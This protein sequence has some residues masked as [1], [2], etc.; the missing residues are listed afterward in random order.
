MNKPMRI[1]ANTTEYGNTEVMKA[2]HVDDY[3]AHLIER[4]ETAEARLAELQKQKPAGKFAFEP[5]GGRWHHIKHGEAQDTEPKL[6]LV[7]LFTHPAPAINLAEMAAQKPRKIFECSSCGC[8]GLDEPPES[9]CHCLGD[10]AYWIEG[11]VF[12]CSAPAINL[13]E[14]V[15][16][17]IPRDVYKVIYEQCEGFV[18]TAANAQAI[19]EAC[20]DAMLRKI[21]E[22]KNV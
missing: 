1:R 4:A 20:R 13:A 11:E 12:T 16:S 15:S 5:V 18:D 19:W 6:P 22:L 14:L 7:K 3:I 2:D 8:E 10:G 9:Q 21:E 17:E